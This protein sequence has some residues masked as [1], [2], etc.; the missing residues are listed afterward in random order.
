TNETDCQRISPLLRCWR[1]TIHCS[2]SAASAHLSRSEVHMRARDRLAQ[3]L[4]E[5]RQRREQEERQRR[6]QVIAEFGADPQAMADEILRYRHG[7]KQ[8]ADA[9]DLMQRGVPFF[10]I[11]GSGALW[12]PKSEESG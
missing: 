3:N 11:V 6:N 9:V 4:A 2:R 8:L 12:K 10:A 5:S 7:L 1:C